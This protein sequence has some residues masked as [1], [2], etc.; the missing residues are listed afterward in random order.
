MNDLESN[1]DGKMFYALFESVKD[2]VFV[3][4]KTGIV[5]NINQNG[6]LKSGYTGKE[7]IGKHISQ[8]TTF[9]TAE[10][11]E[12]ITSKLRAD[13][14]F[15]LESIMKPFDGTKIP[16]EITF[17]IKRICDNEI[18]FAILHDIGLRKE[19]E[20]MLEKR[21]SKYR[22]IFNT[23]PD[24]AIMINKEGKILDVNDAYVK[25]SEYTREELFS[26]NFFDLLSDESRMESV[27][28]IKKA[29]L[30]GHVV[31]DGF[32][33]TKSGKFWHTQISASYWNEGDGFIFVFVNNVSVLAKMM[34]QLEQN[35]QHMLKLLDNTSCGVIIG[36]LDG[37][38]VYVND[39]ISQML[40]YSKN[41]MLK[42]N[43]RDII[44]PDE[45]KIPELTKI[46][47]DVYN[48]NISKYTAEKRYV[49]KDG[50]LITLHLTVSLY[51]GLTGEKL[52]IAQYNHTN[53]NKLTENLFDNQNL[54]KLLSAITNNDFCGILIAKPGD[55]IYYANEFLADMLG[56]SKSEIEKLKPENL[57]HPDELEEA[58]ENLKKVYA[59][60][61]LIYIA[62]RRYL[63]GNGDIITADVTTTKQFDNSGRVFLVAQIENI[64][65]LEQA[66]KTA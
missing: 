2:C 19:I 8:F 23:C 29:M 49:R 27:D 38:F 66:K 33:K 50:Q 17:H 65:K 46:A 39:K 59:G 54:K 26:M 36:R 57:I 21:E 42:L 31:F 52:L 5:L 40:G 64:I 18:I 24:G 13:D 56:Y 60:T 25:T 48:E 61:L 35:R 14:N 58:V 20:R 44:H 51:K 30:N 32:H 53:E 63:H 11:F 12:K 6:L 4:T 34:E 22:I 7:A 41:E 37:S 47:Q 15:V 10:E 62:K 45:L 16:V 1:E 3:L 55:R 9:E 28:Q 43:D